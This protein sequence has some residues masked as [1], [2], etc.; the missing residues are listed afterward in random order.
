MINYVSFA[1]NYKGNN[2]LQSF[3]EILRN[4]SSVSGLEFYKI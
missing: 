2:C 4:D 1:I 3:A